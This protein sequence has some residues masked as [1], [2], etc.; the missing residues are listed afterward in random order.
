MKTI[1]WFLSSLLFFFFMSNAFSQTNIEETTSYK[2]VAQN[3]ETHYNNSAYDSI[4][5]MYGA[6]M[7]DALPLTNSTEFFKGLF[8]Q[9]GK[10]TNREFSRYENESYAVYKTKFERATLGLNIS[11]D[12]KGKINGLFIKPFEEKLDIPTPERNQT[13]LSLPF[14][15]NEKWIVVWGGDTKEQ[16]YHIENQSQK[17]AFDFVIKKEGKSYKT[18]GQ[19]NEDYYAFGKEIFAPCDGEVVLSVDGVKDNKIGKMNTMFVPGN[20]VI[21]KTIN[22]EYLIF[23]HFKQN[24]IKVKEG[25]K[26]KQGELLGLCGNSGNSSEPHLHFHI[27]NTETFNGATGIKCYFDKLIVDGKEKIDYSPV[28][29]EVIEK[30]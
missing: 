20:T 16:N 10:I 17:N 24:S 27:Q 13:Q 19:K 11:I 12:S 30:K 2:K 23:A 26:V 15:K 25:Q 14:S 1:F 5:E 18:D 8:A 9:V 3:F 21:I 29:N 6:G 28:Q 22:N 7:K 4:F